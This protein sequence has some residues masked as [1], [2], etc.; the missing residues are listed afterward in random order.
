VRG[1][2]GRSGPQKRG[3]EDQSA[4][5]DLDKKRV[6]EGEERGAA[7]GGVK[8]VGALEGSERGGEDDGRPATGRKENV[9]KGVKKA[10]GLPLPHSPPLQPGVLSDTLRTAYGG[11]QGANGKGSSRGGYSEKG[12]GFAC[13]SPG[14]C[15]K[16]PVVKHRT[17]QEA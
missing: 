11:G 14:D 13:S 4:E 9:H 16:G 5:R 3:R 10:R 2:L 12:S 6:R 8:D 1:W 17:L 15:K 7:G